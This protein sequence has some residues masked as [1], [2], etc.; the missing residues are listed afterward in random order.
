MFFD[1]LIRGFPIRK[2]APMKSFQC[3]SWLSNTFIYSS[4]VKSV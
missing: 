4:D 3:A 1:L 2:P